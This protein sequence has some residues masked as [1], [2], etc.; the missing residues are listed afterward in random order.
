MHLKLRLRFPVYC[1][2]AIAWIAKRSPG[3]ITSE[4]EVMISRLE[5]AG[6][7]MHDSGVTSRWFG[8]ADD[9]I[10]GVSGQCNGHL[11]EQFLQSSNY[12][13]TDCV[14]LL[15]DGAPTWLLLCC[16][17]CCT[18]CV[19]QVRRLSGNWHVVES[20]H[21]WTLIA[22]NQCRLERLRAL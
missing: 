18:A 1:A 2:Q 17:L 10:R 20:E 3:A 9:G 11:L 15:R 8:N 6:R 13:D 22:V 16:R 4:R 21:R 14:N 7:A 19:L 12:C 5:E